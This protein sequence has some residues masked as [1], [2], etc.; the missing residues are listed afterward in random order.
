MVVSKVLMQDLISNHIQQENELNE[1]VQMTL[2]AVM[3]HEKEAVN[4]KLSNET[5]PMATVQV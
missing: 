3:V 5:R 1:V 2:N 4:T